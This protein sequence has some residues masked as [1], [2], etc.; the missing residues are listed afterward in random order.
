MITLNSTDRFFA[1]NWVS[2][3][4]NNNNNNIIVII[5]IIIIIIVILCLIIT[6]CYGKFGTLSPRKANYDRVAL[7]SVIHPLTTFFSL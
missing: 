7:S 5:I 1:I 6:F 2:N 3:N 4:N